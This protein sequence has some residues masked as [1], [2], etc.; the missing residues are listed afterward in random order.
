LTINRNLASASLIQ[1]YKS[2]KQVYVSRR[3]YKN[4]SERLTERSYYEN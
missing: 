2:H 4:L 3:Y 1:F